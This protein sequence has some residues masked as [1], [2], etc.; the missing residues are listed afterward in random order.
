MRRENEEIIIYKI[1]EP[2][3]PCLTTIFSVYRSHTLHDDMIS[4]CTITMLSP[5]ARGRELQ[6]AQ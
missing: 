6:L 2:Q 4:E 5:G 3:L 1:N